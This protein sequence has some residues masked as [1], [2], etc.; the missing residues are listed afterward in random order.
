M[1]TDNIQAELANLRTLIEEEEVKRRR[2]QAESVRRK[3]NY[4][5]LIVEL[6]KV[7]AKDGQLMPLYE[8]AKERAR[9]KAVQKAAKVK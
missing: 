4:L 2:Q 3:H 5:P 6:L 9:E 8:R 1:E 7:L